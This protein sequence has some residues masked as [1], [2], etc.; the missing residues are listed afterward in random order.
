MGFSISVQ[1]IFWKTGI[2]EDTPKL[3]TSQDIYTNS[4]V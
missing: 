1:E 3:W 4:T 2:T